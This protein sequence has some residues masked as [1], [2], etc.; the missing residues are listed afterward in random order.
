MY[1]LFIKVF[2]VD[3]NDWKILYPEVPGKLKSLHNDG[4]KAQHLN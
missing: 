2:A 3:K 4:F 1:D